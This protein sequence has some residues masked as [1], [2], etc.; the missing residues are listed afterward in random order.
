[1]GFFI[2]DGFAAPPLAQVQAALNKE[3]P[4]VA[5]IA[6]KI[7]GATGND[8][9]LLEADFALSGGPSV[10][11]DSVFLLV[12]AEGVKPLVSEAAAIN[13]VRDAFAHLKAIGHVSAAQPLLDA[14]LVEPDAAVV[15][16]SD[17]KSLAKYVKAAKSGRLWEREPKLRSIG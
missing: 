13:W 3:K 6:P 7:G 11:F 5:L 17:K 15:A 14:A 10:L 2:T 16:V 9:S 4:A 12:S 1:M 8:G